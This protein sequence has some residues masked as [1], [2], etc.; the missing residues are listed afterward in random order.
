MEKE[1]KYCVTPRF[2]VS[3]PHVFEPHSGFEN[4][5][6][7]YSITMLFD[8]KA[9]LKDLKR[10]V[11]NATIEKW[12][13]DEK[14]WPKNLRSPFRDGDE[15]SDLQG[16]EGMIFVSASSKQRPS[17]VDQK[18]EKINKEDETFYAGCYARASLIAFAYDAMGNKGI[19]FG[20]QNV[21]KLADGEQFSGRKKAED[22]FEEVEDESDSKENYSDDEDSDLGLD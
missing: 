18:K 11:K 9:D 10:A 19:S 16:Y 21:Q 20:L 4:Q 14:K 2:R 17:V 1:K 6:P 3:F 22:E 5:E 13:I 12:G 15:K 7:K 8:S